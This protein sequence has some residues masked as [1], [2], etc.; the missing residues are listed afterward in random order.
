MRL[1]CDSDPP[2]CSYRG[3]SVFPR[4]VLSQ[5]GSAHCRRTTS[6]TIMLSMSCDIRV[7]TF[8]TRAQ[9]MLVD[10]LRAEYRDEI[11]DWCKTLWINAR[12]RMCLAH[13]RYAGCNNN[14]GIEVSWRDI[15]KLCRRTALCRSSLA[16]SATTLRPTWERSTCI[17]DII[18]N[19]NAFIRTPIPTKEMWDGVQSAHIKTLSCSFV[20]ASSSKRAN[21]PIIFWDVMEE[22]MESWPV[23]MPLHLRIA[24]W[25]NDQMRSATRLD[26]GEIKKVLVPRQAI[27]EQGC[28]KFR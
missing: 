10:H 18:G 4:L 9:A 22:V 17:L 8:A 12:G 27:S 19:R 14:M 20:I 1:C 7:D 11:A 6:I 15:K 25:H 24:A 3:I 13:S 2:A 23:T 28:S 5:P 21:V 26:M 16:R